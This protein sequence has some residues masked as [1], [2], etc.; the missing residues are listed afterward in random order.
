MTC[1]TKVFRGWSLSFQM[2]IP[3]QLTKEKIILPK[4]RWLTKRIIGKGGVKDFLEQ[5]KTVEEASK[6]GLREELFRKAKH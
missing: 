1:K 5:N 3:S 2:L 6:M 4:N